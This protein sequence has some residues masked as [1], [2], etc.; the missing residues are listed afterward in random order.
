MSRASL[1][2]LAAIA[3]L[4]ST[5]TSE[6]HE[7]LENQKWETCGTACPLTCDSF[8]E[9]QVACTLA[10]L[11]HNVLGDARQIKNGLL[12]DQHVSRP[13]LNQILKSALRPQQS[14]ISR[15]KYRIITR[16]TMSRASLVLLVAIAVLFSTATSQNQCPEDQEWTTCGS[17]C[18]PSCTEPNPQVCTAARLPHK[19]LGDARQIK[20]GPL[21]DQHVRRPVTHALIK[22][23]HWQAHLAKS[24]AMRGK[25]R[26]DRMWNSMCA[27]LCHGFCT[28]HNGTA[29]SQ[30]S[31]SC[32]EN[33]EWTTCGS[34]C[35]ERCDTDP[36]HPKPCILKCV[37]GCQCKENFV[38][39]SNGK[40]VSK[41]EC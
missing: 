29:T 34:A 5:A 36:N 22:F 11:P 27:D 31:E 6:D 28:L 13:A 9:P 20:N 38:L 16:V 12:V 24:S 8:L 10:R 2:L 21:V 33:Q 3:V 40:C 41:N 18:P 30:D 19:V 17:A 25:S 35:P 14:R 32:P 7:C 1:V 37:I 23:A 4:F 26:M 15:I 39:N